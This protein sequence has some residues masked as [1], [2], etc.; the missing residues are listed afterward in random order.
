[1]A[2]AASETVV[3]KGS[4]LARLAGSF[5]VQDSSLK[6]CKPGQVVGYQEGLPDD[7]LISVCPHD[8]TDK[9]RD[10]VW[11]FLRNLGRSDVE[12][13]SAVI[14]MAGKTFTYGQFT[15]PAGQGLVLANVS[16]DEWRAGLKA[17]VGKVGFEVVIK[18]TARGPPQ[19]QPPVVKNTD[20]EGRSNSLARGFLATLSS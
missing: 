17:G 8:L 6:K 4:R 14:T 20:I 5:L 13:E 1:M 16:H 12:V 2:C 7:I 3:G 15:V 9:Q 19:E 10:W 18:D 11:V